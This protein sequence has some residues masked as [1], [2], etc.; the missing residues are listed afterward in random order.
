[1]QTAISVS[2]TSISGG[3]SSVR[4]IVLS[5][6]SIVSPSSS[7]ARTPSSIRS[8]HPRFRD[9]LLADARATARH[10]GERSEFTSRADAVVQV[11]RLACLSD[12]FL[13]QALYRLKARLQAIG[14]PVLPRLAHRLA[15]VLG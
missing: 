8:R 6:V 13:A 5:S 12:A 7:V 10:R 4:L 1:M 14:I 3:A 11:V 15:M 2:G 9:A